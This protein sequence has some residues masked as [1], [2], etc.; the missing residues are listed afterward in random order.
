MMPA[1]EMNDIRCVACG[2]E[3][4]CHTQDERT[5]LR[6]SEC[7]ASYKNVLG[8][9]FFGLYEEEDLL[10]LI[11]I[12]ANIVN[13]GNFGVTPDVVEDWENLMLAYEQATDKNDF[14]K[15]NP[16]AQSPF[17]LNRYGEWVEIAH[18]TSELNLRGCK[19]LDIGAGLGFDSHR[20]SMRGASVT[21]LEFSPVLAESGHMNFPH[22]R[23]IGGFS[24]F[25]PFKGA[26]F[27]AVF[28]N[29]ALHHMRDIPATI[30]EALRVLRPG[31]LLITTCDSFRANDSGKDVELNIFDKDPAVLL[32]VN[33]CVP[34]FSDFVSTLKLHPEILDVEL[35]THTLHNAPK[36]GTL[37][38]FTCWS[39]ASDGPML[40]KRSG[41]LAMR[42]R[43]KC[44]WPEPAR[45]Q[46]HGVLA[47]DEYVSWVS[48]ASFAMAKL[49]RLMPRKYV[50]LPFPGNEGMK[51]ELLNGWRLPKKFHQARVAY[52]RGRWFLRRPSGKDTLVFDFSLPAT[53]FSNVKSLVVLT[54]R[55]VV[56]SR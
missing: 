54:V 8:V 2:N 37:T 15:N 49:A 40:S 39:L 1:F 53:G 23:W 6:C 34:K 30:S 32:G 4:L 42:V 5:C 17:L 50:D 29:A 55:H 13:R 31:G 46:T 21:A 11:E 19:V 28:C 7:A 20:L 45:R 24:H 47:A 51:F 48:S 18:L 9:P 22:I 35:Y 36:G 27:D 52:Q 25:L 38:E 33:E 56:T 26:S 10:G 44:A 43:L 3:H 14:V 41:S 16:N 12:A